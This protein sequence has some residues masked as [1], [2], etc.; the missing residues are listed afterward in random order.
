MEQ[1]IRHLNICRSLFD[2][3]RQID[4]AIPLRTDVQVIEPDAVT[5]H[6]KCTLQE[7]VDRAVSRKDLK[8]VH[9]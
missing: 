6:G 8:I 9:R 2:A 3:E 7:T 4:D 1:W 5:R